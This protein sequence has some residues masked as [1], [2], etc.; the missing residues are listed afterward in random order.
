MKQKRVIVDNGP[1]VAFLN[2][3]DSYHEW[4]K[5]QFAF[6]SFPFISCEAVISE[7]C[8]LL[9]SFPNGARNVLELLERELIILPFD[10]EAESNSIKILPESRYLNCLKLCFYPFENTGFGWAG[11]IQADDILQA[12]GGH[13]LTDFRFCV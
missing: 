13:H 5:T 3:N 11:V 9:R 6:I 1:I 10:L 4:A 8:F 7:A 2:K 12:G